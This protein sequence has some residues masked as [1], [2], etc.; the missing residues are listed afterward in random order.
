MAGDVDIAEAAVAPEFMSVPTAL[1]DNVITPT[2]WA[3]YVHVNEALAPPAIA[4]F[5]AGDVRSTIPPVEPVTTNR[6]SGLT[7]VAEAVPL[8]VTVITIV[9]VCPRLTGVET[10]TLSDDRRF[11]GACMV[12]IFD[13]AR[14]LLA[15]IAVRAS[16]P[17]AF[18]LKP[19]VPA[20]VA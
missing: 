17:V 16:V 8:L 2:P 13:E 4:G 14:G 12:T 5:I 20:V 1:P 11:A 19:N 6:L 9:T 10:S 7:L 15:L 18:P 3:S